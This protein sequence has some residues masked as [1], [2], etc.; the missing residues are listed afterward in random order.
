MLAV[1]PATIFLW[2]LPAEG[3]AW[4]HSPPSPPPFF[5]AH[6]TTVFKERDFLPVCHSYWESARHAYLHG[7]AISSP[8]SPSCFFRQIIRVNTQCAYELVG[9]RF[10]CWNDYL[11]L[12]SVEKEQRAVRL[13]RWK[14]RE[15]LPCQENTQPASDAVEDH[16]PQPEVLARGLSL[17][18]PLCKAQH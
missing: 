12:S 17:R 6:R 4:S 8:E 1:L 7:N 13:D 15:P 10:V 9:R 18:S 16:L 14:E 2:S 3:T 11:G 5:I